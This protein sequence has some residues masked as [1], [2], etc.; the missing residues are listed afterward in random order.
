M[1]NGLR[2]LILGA[3]VAGLIGPP[4]VAHA[5]CS[6][7][8]EL[9]QAAVGCYYSGDE[10]KAAMGSSDGAKWTVVQQCK[11]GG[12][13]GVCAN[14]I[15]CVNSAGNAG[16]LY[17]VFR[18]PPGGARQLY[19]VACLTTTEAGQ[20]GAITPA[21]VYEAMQRLSWP[22]SELVV[23]PPGG[24]TLVNLATNVYTTNTEATTQTVTLLGQRVVIEATPRSYVWHW[25]E[26]GG[27]AGSET[28]S[29]PGAPYPHLEVTH[30]YRD[31]GLTVH[32]W[33][34]TVYSGRYTVNGGG[35]TDVPDT[36]TVPGPPVSLRVL[37]AKPVLVG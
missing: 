28:T 26:R 32:P 36:L 37:E 24:K 34:D 19:G 13:A 25:A 4:A 9:D 22:R 23:Q 2:F 12:D 5:D 14:P 27:D 31:A 29:S 15:A 7:D 21:M 1:R 10:V 11:S 17:N 16:T 6:T 3:I 33:V 20:L 35:W 8:V 18:T 30:T